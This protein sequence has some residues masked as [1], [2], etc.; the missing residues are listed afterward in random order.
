[1]QATMKTQTELIKVSCGIGRSFEEAARAVTEAKKNK[2]KDDFNIKVYNGTRLRSKLPES[3]KQRV[4]EYLL[5]A[6]ELSN[7]QIKILENFTL[8]D[9]LTG[10]LNKTGFVLKLEELKQK[11]INEG[12]YILFDLDDL[13]DW[14]NKL[15]YN[16]VD[17]YIE[18]IGQ[19]I[20]NNI[21][22]GDFCS[23]DKRVAD[24]VGHRLNESAGDEFLIFV[25]AEHNEKNVERL[26]V[27]ATRLLEK[28]YEKQIEMKALKN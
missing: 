12:Y 19:A 26:K 13:H 18:M 11:G 17:R 1:M 14:N 25:P 16:E 8:K 23:S 6:K 22:H 3:F 9:P 10:L 28:I 5:L 20:K 15:G 4:Q 27:L 21:R 2:G 24:I 7:D